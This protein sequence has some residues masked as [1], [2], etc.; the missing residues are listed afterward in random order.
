M[1]VSSICHTSREYSCNEQKPLSHACLLFPVPDSTRTSQPAPLNVF[2]LS[3]SLRAFFPSGAPESP[4]IN[5]TITQRAENTIACVSEWFFDIFGISGLPGRVNEP[6]AGVPEETAKPSSHFQQPLQHSRQVL[7]N[8][9]S[10]HDF[11]NRRP[12]SRICLRSRIDPAVVTDD[13]YRSTY[14]RQS[15]VCHHT[16]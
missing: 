1:T 16:R 13:V 15:S 8:S 9:I 2:L 12:L 4:R 5:N 7:P 14:S 10:K 11:R 3:L 6:A